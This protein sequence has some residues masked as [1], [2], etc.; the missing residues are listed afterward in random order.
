MKKVLIVLGIFLFIARF[1]VVDFTVNPEEREYRGYMVTDNSGDNTEG[2]DR[3][4][5]KGEK[6]S[7]PPS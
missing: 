5:M 1:F 2:N 3:M 4:D 6:P 7:R